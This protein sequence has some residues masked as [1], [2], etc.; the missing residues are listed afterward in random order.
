M[1]LLII[2]LTLTQINPAELGEPYRGGEYWFRT[3]TLQYHALPV[4]CPGEAA[5]KVLRLRRIVQGVPMTFT[6]YQLYPTDGLM[7]EI[8]I[9]DI[10]TACAQPAQFP[11]PLGPPVDLPP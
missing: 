6:L 10:P 2:I 9:P 8:P 3:T 7:N 5:A 11:L 1:Y 4:R